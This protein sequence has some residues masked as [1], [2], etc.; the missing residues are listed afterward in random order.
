MYLI[1]Q[2]YRE[3]RWNDNNHEQDELLAE[4]NYTAVSDDYEIAHDEACGYGDGR[5]SFYDADYY[6]VS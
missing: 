2:F 6:T 3:V 5:L 1:V 4:D